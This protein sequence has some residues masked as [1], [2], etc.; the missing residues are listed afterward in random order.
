MGWSSAEA[1]ERYHRLRFCLG[2]GWGCVGVVW[3]WGGVS[4]KQLI[5]RGMKGGKQTENK[6]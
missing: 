4:P 2:G 1:V 3:L 6:R 5:V